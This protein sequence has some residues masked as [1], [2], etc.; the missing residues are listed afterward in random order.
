[1]LVLSNWILFYFSVEWFLCWK[2]PA[3]VLCFLCSLLSCCFTL[4]VDVRCAPSHKCKFS[5]RSS[6][7]YGGLAHKKRDCIEYA[8][9]RCIW[10]LDAVFHVLGFSCLTFVLNVSKTQAFFLISSSKFV[11]LNINYWRAF[12]S[13]SFFLSSSPF[14]S[15]C[16]WIFQWV[17]TASALANCIPLWHFMSDSIHSG[18]FLAFVILSYQSVV[19]FCS[20]AIQSSS[21]QTNEQYMRTCTRTLNGFNNKFD[22]IV[23]CVSLCVYL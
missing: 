3:L 2:S 12:H 5:S 16:E 13:F 4:C 23:K 10:H 1:M 19:L 17:M 22:Q 7:I 9:H 11:T 18:F 20:R 6:F 14:H 15:L 8:S 21:T